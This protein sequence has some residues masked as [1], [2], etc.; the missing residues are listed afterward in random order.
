MN[1][2]QQNHANALIGESFK[3]LLYE[4][5][6][7]KIEVET[8]I[9]EDGSFSTTMHVVYPDGFG[10]EIFTVQEGFEKLEL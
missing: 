6:I 1:N 9:L 4:S 2:A 5:A 3:S 8:E 7:G 10:D